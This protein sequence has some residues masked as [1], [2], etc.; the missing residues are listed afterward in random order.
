MAAIAREVMIHDILV[1]LCYIDTC[2]LK[3]VFFRTLRE[4]DDHW[5]I[6]Y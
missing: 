4:N 3:N 5:V 1:Q 6:M 2:N